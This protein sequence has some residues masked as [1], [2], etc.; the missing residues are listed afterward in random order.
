MLFSRNL[1]GVISLSFISMKNQPCKVR[2]EIINVNN[3]E[4]VKN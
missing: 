1:P 3:N 4:H 2:P